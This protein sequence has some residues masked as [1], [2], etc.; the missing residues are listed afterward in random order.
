[1]ILDQFF[2]ILKPLDTSSIPDFVIPKNVIDYK[3]LFKTKKTRNK[4]IKIKSLNFQFIKSLQKNLNE[5]EIL[6]FS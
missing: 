3:I 1:M 6:V 2:N 5:T 4:K